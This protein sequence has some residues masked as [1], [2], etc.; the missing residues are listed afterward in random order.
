MKARELS[1][2]GVF[3]FTPNIIQDDRGAFLEYYRHDLMAERTGRG[4]PL[5]Q[6]NCSVSA[7]GVLRGIHFAD[8]PPG[9]AKYVT[10]TSGAVFDVAVDLR[11]DSPTFG[12]WDAVRLDDVERKALYLPEGVGHGFMA[13]SE[14]AIVAYLCSTPYS[15]SAEHTV[16]ALD[17][18]LA[19]SWP[20]DLEPLLSARD[21][22]ATG[23][24][25][26]H[27]AGGLPAYRDCLVVSE[28][29]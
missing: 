6:A 22:Q 19:I 8:V 9:Q 21:A 10:C 23:F 27:A 13:L 7:R 12:S 5:A 29:P 25:D 14:Q 16:Y 4:M 20:Q 15:P 3:E 28:Q 1:V 11:T 26:M 24:A 17:V 18:D 2:S